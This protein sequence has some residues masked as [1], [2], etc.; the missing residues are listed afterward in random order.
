MVKN[1]TR[2]IENFVC[3]NCGFLVVGDGYTNHCPKCLFCKHV[4]INPGDRMSECGGI[5]KP[6]ELQKTGQIYSLIHKCQKCGFLRKNKLSKE[7]DFDKAV[8]LSKK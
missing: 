2:N 3:D 1:F 8:A 7:D 6:I 5:M 4:D